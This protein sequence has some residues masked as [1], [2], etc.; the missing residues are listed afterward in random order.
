L[1]PHPEK[2]KLGCSEVLCLGHVVSA[3]GIIPNPEKI[4]AVRD[5]PTPTK[6]KSL[7]E[8]LD[9]ASYYCRFVLRFAKVLYALTKNN[10]DFTWTPSIYS[11]ERTSDLPSH[12]FIS[13]V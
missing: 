13:L 6:E 1:K 4:R 8:F 5:F 9:L 12:T 2:C 11:I 7:R 3:E 10:T